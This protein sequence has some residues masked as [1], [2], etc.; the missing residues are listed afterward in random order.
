[1][2]KLKWD[3]FGHGPSKV[4]GS[5][6]YTR[7]CQTNSKNTAKEIVRGLRENGWLVRVSKQPRNDKYPYA[8]YYRTKRKWRRR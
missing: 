5:R 4:I 3:T 6:S 1:M 7:R 8:V 2:V